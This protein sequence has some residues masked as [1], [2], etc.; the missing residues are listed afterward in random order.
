MAS[1]EDPASVLQPIQAD[2]ADPA[3]VV[4]ANDFEAMKKHFLIPEPYLDVEDEQTFTW[5]IDN[6]RF[7]DPR[8]SSASGAGSQL[9]ENKRHSEVVNCGGQPWRILLFPY[10]NNSD[11]ASAY[12]EHAV[13]DPPQDW[14]CCVQFMLAMWNPQDPSVYTVHFAK[15]RFTPEVRDWGFTKFAELRKLFASQW[16]NKSRPMIE[17][18]RV[19]ITAYLRVYQDPTGVLWHDFIQYV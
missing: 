18:D 6:W 16:E 14:Y 2:G 17:D 15:H 4:S 7:P 10:G 13:D 5:E 1:Q 9:Q 11:S 12:L 8:S 19:N 3:T